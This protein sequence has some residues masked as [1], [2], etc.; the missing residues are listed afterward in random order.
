MRQQFHEIFFPDPETKWKKYGRKTVDNTKWR[1][2]SSQFGHSMGFIFGYLV[3]RELPL[4][5]FYA[6]SII[7]FS[8]VLKFM[9]QYALPLPIISNISNGT[10]MRT[11]DYHK[12]RLANYPIAEKVSSTFTPAQSHNFYATYVQWAMG[13]PGQIDIQRQLCLNTMGFAFAGAKPVA[14]DGTFNMPTR[15]L[16]DKN[17]KYGAG[18]KYL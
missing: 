6:R 13:S 10:V 9:S 18:L 7:M 5:N 8:F 1:E 2:Y 16:A 4:R 11:D 15:G 14:W 17:S 12:R 3:L